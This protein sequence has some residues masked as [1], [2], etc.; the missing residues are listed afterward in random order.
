MCEFG[1]FVI[2]SR[3]GVHSFHE[4]RIIEMFITY[5]AGAVTPL[6]TH[7]YTPIFPMDKVETENFD[8]FH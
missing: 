4:I 6:L 5:S 8:I 2:F 3:Y 7:F 1:C